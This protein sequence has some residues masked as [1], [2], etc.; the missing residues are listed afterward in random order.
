MSNRGPC[1]EDRAQDAPLPLGDMVNL[2]VC[3]VHS[4]ELPLDILEGFG[5]HVLG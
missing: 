3:G 2:Y 5:T 1:C 4:H